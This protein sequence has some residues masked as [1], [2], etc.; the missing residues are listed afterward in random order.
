[1]DLWRWWTAHMPVMDWDL[2]GKLRVQSRE[3]TVWADTPV[4]LDQ[5]T[6]LR[7]TIHTYQSDESVNCAHLCIHSKRGQA[8]FTVITLIIDKRKTWMK[9]CTGSSWRALQLVCCAA[10][11]RIE[12]CLY[13]LLRY[14]R[15]DCFYSRDRAAHSPAG[16]SHSR[17]RVNFLPPLQRCLDDWWRK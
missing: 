9:Y 10:M 6:T 4:L 11:Q 17:D 3:F 1:M 13:S 16:W 7:R 8:K 5:V 15:A 12:V 2:L 14:S